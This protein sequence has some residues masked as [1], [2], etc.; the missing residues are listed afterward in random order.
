MESRN[1]LSYEKEKDYRTQEVQY[2]SHPMLKSEERK[3]QYPCMSNWV[4]SRIVHT[5]GNLCRKTIAIIV[6]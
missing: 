5:P 1:A 3:S 4:H 6:V 2:I